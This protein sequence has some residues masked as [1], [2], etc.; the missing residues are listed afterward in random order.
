MAQ[1]GAE[2][3]V[4]VVDELAEGDEGSERREREVPRGYGL[5]SSLIGEALRDGT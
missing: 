5:G 2:D 3:R 1:G 4:D